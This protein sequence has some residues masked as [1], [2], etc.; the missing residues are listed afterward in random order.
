MG[1]GRKTLLDVADVGNHRIGRLGGLH[2]FEQ[3]GIAGQRRGVLPGHLEVAGCPDRVPFAFGDDTD[4]FAAAHHPRRYS[5]D[6]GLV[7]VEG[8][9]SRPISALAARAHDAAV[10]H[11][12]D[13]HVLHVHIFAD[14]LVGN[15]DA[16][17]PRADQPVAADR[18]L[19]RGAG[20]RDVERL[21]ADQF[22]VGD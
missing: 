19:R 3:L 15:I 17:H 1:G 10:Q 8:L 5:G 22:A 12:S 18:L 21:V 16:R 11:A 2:S 7:D 6:R 4:E 9:R 13:A 14:D 20:E